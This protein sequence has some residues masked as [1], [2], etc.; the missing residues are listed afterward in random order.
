[1][2]R[3]KQNA[4]PQLPTLWGTPFLATTPYPLPPT[5]C[6]LH[7]LGLLRPLTTPLARGPAPTVGAIPSPTHSP[8]SLQT[9]RAL[10]T[11]LEAG[12]GENVLASLPHPH[13]THTPRLTCR[14]DPRRRQLPS[15][16]F[17]GLSLTSW[18]APELLLQFGQWRKGC[19]RLVLWLENLTLPRTGFLFCFDFF[20]TFP[21]SLVNGAARARIRSAL[22]GLASGSAPPRPRGKIP[23]N[24]LLVGRGGVG[25]PAQPEVGLAGR[26]PRRGG[27]LGLP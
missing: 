11:H 4:S 3:E 26:V 12:N 5:L 1:M 27:L 24:L 14:P 13:P 19:H 25:A 21:R 17:C 23:T 16:S 2:N 20:R 15:L 7:P 18:S 22:W 10:L 6:R 8:Q 9:A